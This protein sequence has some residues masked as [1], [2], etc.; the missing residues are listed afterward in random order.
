MDQ[1]F[2]VAGDM[3]TLQVSSL[4]LGTLPFG[5]T[6][7]PHTAFELLDRF[8]EGGGNF[9]DSANNYAYWADGA[10]GGESEEVLGR[11]LASRGVRDR[12]VLATKVGARPAEPG[13]DVLEGLSPAVIR[14][15]LE[16]SLKRLRTDRIDLFYT[17][18]DDRSVP[19]EDILGTLAELAAAGKIRE[20]GCSNHVTWRIERSRA[21]ASQQGLPRY[22]AI[23][24]RYTYLRPRPDARFG[25]QEHV[26][27]ELLD[28]VRC[29]DV[30]LLAYSP[31][32]H[33]AYAGGRPIRP[34]YEHDGTAARLRELSLVAGELGLTPSQVVLAWLLRSDP[35]VLPVVGVTRPAQLTQ[36]LSALDADLPDELY[37]RLEKAGERQ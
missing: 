32:M 11:W 27:D 12:V 2:T 19:F 21:I 37:Q 8:L 31:L 24:Q 34:E 25:I 20:I 26:T 16:A 14:T 28:Y 36:A 23:Q 30:A 17:H 35:P 1:Q 7:D 33:G 4:C 6:V 18:I 5:T 9:L 13:S 22:A 15:Q 3:D 29:N 10:V